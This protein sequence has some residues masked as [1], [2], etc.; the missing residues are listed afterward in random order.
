MSRQPAVDELLFQCKVALL[1]M[2]WTEFRFHDTRKWR[3]DV[4]FPHQKLAVEIDGGGFVQGRHGRG[5]GIEADCEKFAEAMLL[6]W[7]VLRVTPKH[8]K[9][10]QALDWITRLLA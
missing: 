9:S 7:R 6:G 2:P 8:V 3:F 10:G 1:P 4:V 5:K